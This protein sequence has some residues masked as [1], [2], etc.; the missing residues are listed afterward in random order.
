[1]NS[2]ADG[3]LSVS[4]SWPKGDATFD[5]SET[6]K[7]LDEA[8]PSPAARFVKSRADAGKNISY[9]IFQLRT[10]EVVIRWNEKDPNL[11][12]FFFPKE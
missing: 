7:V 11:E 10:G 3:R 9:G 12:L 2:L 8:R 5:I 4:I 6:G 1:L